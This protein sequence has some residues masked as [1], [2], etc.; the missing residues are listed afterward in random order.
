[1][2]ARNLNKARSLQIR[3]NPSLR[4]Q[5]VFRIHQTR[6]VFWLSRYNLGKKF[7]PLKPMV[8]VIKNPHEHKIF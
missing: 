4:E 8:K 1:M 3:A 5:Y 7:V 6:P 2:F